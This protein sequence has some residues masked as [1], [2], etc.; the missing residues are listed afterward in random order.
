M[1]SHIS[2]SQSP[3]LPVCI[4]AKIMIDQ[5]GHYQASITKTR[6]NT[7]FGFNHPAARV[8]AIRYEYKTPNCWSAGALYFVAP[9]QVRPRHDAFPN[10]SVFGWILFHHRHRNSPL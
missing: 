10:R 7:A 4:D 9:G 5:V 6:A 2:D 8:N 1:I 3:R